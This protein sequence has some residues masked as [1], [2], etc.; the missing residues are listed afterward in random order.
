MSALT[1]RFTRHFIMAHRL[2]VG[3]SLKCATPHGHNERVIVDLVAKDDTP[4][5]DGGENVLVEFS[6]A[7]GRWHRFVDEALDHG[8]QLSSDDP[9]LAIV[10]QHFPTWRVVVTPG[11]PATELLCALL[12]HKCQT[13]L[14]ADETGLRVARL[15]IEE[16]PTNTV[17]FEGDPR[18]AIPE[19]ALAATRDGSAWWARADQS[20][21]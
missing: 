18:E 2:A 11:D 7:K 4:R 10:D 6:K 9:F 19:R 17:V 5:L 16:T 13:F 12:A 15:T 8:L 1:L 3:E 14:D 21:R 20:T